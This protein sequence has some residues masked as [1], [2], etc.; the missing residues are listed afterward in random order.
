MDAIIWIPYMKKYGIWIWKKIHICHICPTLK[1][2]DEGSRHLKFLHVLFDIKLT[3]MKPIESSAK[4]TARLTSVLSRLIRYTCGPKTSKHR[5]FMLL[6]QSI[7]FC[8]MSWMRK[9]SYMCS[10]GGKVQ[11]QLSHSVEG[12][13]S[14]HCQSYTDR[15]K[16]YLLE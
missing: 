10:K 12:D 16:V 1:I 9:K 8:G 2:L 14:S 5:L 7:Q 4:K 11:R 3:Y 6:T 13:R 15:T